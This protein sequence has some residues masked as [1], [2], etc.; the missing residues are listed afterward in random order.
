MGKVMNIYEENHR[1]V[2]L[3]FRPL[4]GT[5]VQQMVALA[6]SEGG[7]LGTLMSKGAAEDTK[8]LTVHPPRHVRATRWPWALVSGRNAGGLFC[9]NPKGIFIANFHT[10][11]HFS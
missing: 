10:L 5:H 7:V 4:R 6:R 11:E 9:G 8:T 2:Q 3:S 1:F